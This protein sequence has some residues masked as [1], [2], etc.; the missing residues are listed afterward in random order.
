MAD[1]PSLYTLCHLVA[2]MSFC[3]IYYVH[4]LPPHQT[5]GLPAHGYW[6]NTYYWTYTMPGSARTFTW[7]IVP[8]TGKKPW[9]MHSGQGHTRSLFH[10]CEV[11]PLYPY[12]PSK[13]LLHSY[14]LDIY[15]WTFTMLGPAHGQWPFSS[16]QQVQENHAFSCTC[17]WGMVVLFEF[18][19]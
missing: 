8:L 13:V 5:S 12:P 18:E 16:K 10:V 11:Y 4:P 3:P 14:W 15:Y 6:G 19:F 2:R 17:C 1:I 7:A 9:A